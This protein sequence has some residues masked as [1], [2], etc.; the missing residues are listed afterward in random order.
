MTPA[1]LAAAGDPELV[2]LGLALAVVVMPIV[3]GIATYNRIVRLRQHMREAWAD[4]DV[5]LKRRHDLIP[6][7]VE[8]VRAY[9]AHEREVLARLIELRNKAAADDTPRALGE[10]ETALQRQLGRVFAIAEAYPELRADRHFLELQRELALTED[11]LAAARRF[12]NGNVRELNS[13][14]QTFPSNMVAGMA[15]ATTADYFELASDAERVA[16]RLSM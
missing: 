2:M 8:T 7:L 15:G 9:A 13:L 3:Y 6:N 12:Y 1:P 11:R 4:V 16:P 14:V 5:E 10:D